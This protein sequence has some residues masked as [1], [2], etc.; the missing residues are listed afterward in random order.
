MAKTL[1]SRIQY[2][3]DEKDNW[4]HCTD[5][6]LKGEIYVHADGSI[7]QHVTVGDG[8]TVNNAPKLILNKS[9]IIGGEGG[10]Y[11]PPSEE[12]PDPTPDLPTT[13][14]TTIEKVPTQKGTLTFS[15]EG[16]QGLLRSPDWND[17]DE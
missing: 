4:A 10:G 8:G 6:S 15:Y 1:N 13:P 16:G 12:E 14:L 17:Y 7:A 5:I 2:Q 3:Y 11:V 9:S